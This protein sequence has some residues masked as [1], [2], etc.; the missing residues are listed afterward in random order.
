MSLTVQAHETDVVDVRRPIRARSREADVGL[1]R[2]RF[3]ENALCQRFRMLVANDEIG[4]RYF[5][6]FVFP[7]R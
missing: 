1:I 5:M 3:G 2:L 6:G 4:T 7:A